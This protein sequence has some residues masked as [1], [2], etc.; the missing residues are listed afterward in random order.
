VSV[1][2]VEWLIV[3]PAALAAAVAFGMAA[4]LVLVWRPFAILAVPSPGLDSSIGPICD[5]ICRHPNRGSRRGAGRLT[6]QIS[7]TG[8]SVLT[9]EQVAIDLLRPD[10]A[11]P[12]R[13]GDQE[14][15]ALELS[16]RQFGF[17]QPVLARREDH[18][19]IGVH[20][21]L[22]AARRLGLTSVPVNARAEELVA[23]LVE[24]AKAEALDKLGEG[25]RALD[26]AAGW[27]RAKMAPASADAPPR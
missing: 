10:P 11:N 18:T 9:V 25:R 26:I 2:T 23:D 24:P 12:R 27:V 4:A 6:G 19:V 14:L 16:L 5:Q 13:I 20:Q 17:V 3:G 1:A 22:V 21:R 7:M 15:D 8:V